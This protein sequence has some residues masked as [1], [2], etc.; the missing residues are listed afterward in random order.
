[1]V[2]KVVPDKKEQAKVLSTMKI[3]EGSSIALFT[4]INGHMRQATGNYNAVSALTIINCVWGLSCAI[5]LDQVF[6]SKAE[7]KALEML[8]MEQ[9]E[10]VDEEASTVE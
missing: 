9:A 7:C 2:N 3:F 4:Y 8:E 6:K 1:M 10:L 5:T